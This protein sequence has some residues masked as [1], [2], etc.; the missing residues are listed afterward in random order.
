ME[1]LFLDRGPGKRRVRPSLDASMF[2]DAEESDDFE[3][4]EYKPRDDDDDN[5]S[6]RASD[7]GV[8]NDKDKE[9]ERFRLQLR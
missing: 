2:E 6:A 8:A 7:G 9:D 3:N 1:F 4:D 5:V